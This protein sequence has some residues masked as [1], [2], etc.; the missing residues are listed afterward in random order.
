M[1]L[2]T[3]LDVL[4]ITVAALC[5]DINH[6]GLNNAFLVQD[7]NPLALE[8]NDISPL[9]NMHSCLT[10]R[11]LSQDD[12]KNDIFVSLSKEQYKE[13]RQNIIRAILST[14]MANHLELTKR[15]QVCFLCPPSFFYLHSPLFCLWYLV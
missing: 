4:S 6:Q 13:V 8:Y 7:K 14:D 1:S 11:I 5:H 12:G 9:E 15:L 10:F 3:F 2:I